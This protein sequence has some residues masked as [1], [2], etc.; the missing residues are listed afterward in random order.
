MVATNVVRKI[1]QPW[2]QGA[3]ADVYKGEYNGDDVAI[4]HIRAFNASTPPTE[5]AR[6]VRSPPP[7]NITTYPS[8]VIISKSYLVVQRGS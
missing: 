8:S 6:K 7:L 3:F 1:A 5:K 4:K 2:A